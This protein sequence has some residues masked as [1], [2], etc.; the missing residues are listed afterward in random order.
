[1]LTRVLGYPGMVKTVW[2]LLSTVLLGRDMDMQ[3]E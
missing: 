3:G 2:W 1:M